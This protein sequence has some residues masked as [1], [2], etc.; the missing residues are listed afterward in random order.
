MIFCLKRKRI[1]MTWQS[2]WRQYFPLMN[3]SSFFFSLAKYFCPLFATNACDKK[4]N[5]CSSFQYVF[6]RVSLLKNKHLKED[7]ES[8]VLYTALL[9][10]SL[11]WIFNVRERKVKY[12]LI[13]KV[14]QVV[15]KGMINS[16]RLEMCVW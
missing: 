11:Q 7:A 9:Y 16:Q 8:L 3:I 5:Y 2:V 15:I 4:L 6:L 14:R 13:S 10:Y 12:M 1:C